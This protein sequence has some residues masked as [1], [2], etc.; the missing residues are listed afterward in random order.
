MEKEREREERE[1]EK[2][3][4]EREGVKRDCSEEFPHRQLIE[5]VGDMPIR[6]YV[7]S[8]Q[9]SAALI[10]PCSHSILVTY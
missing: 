4:R 2:R 5:R 7:L 1:R 6:E 3:E 8:A 9:R 10:A